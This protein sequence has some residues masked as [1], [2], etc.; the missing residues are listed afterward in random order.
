MLDPVKKRAKLYAIEGQSIPKG[1]RVGTVET[2]DGA[3]IRYARWRA[4]KDV[5]TDRPLG[6][7]ILLQGRSECIEKYYET[8][9]EFRSWGFCVLVFDWRGQGASQRLLPNAQKGHIENFNQYL[10]DLEAILTQ[11]A[12]PDCKPPL[13]IVAHSTGALVSLMAAP[14]LGNRIER[15]VLATPL[16]RL[17]NLPLRQETLQRALGIASF[18]GFSRTYL[19]K[20]PLAY[21]TRKFEGN[22]LTSDP[23]R[24]ARN[25]AIFA[26]HPFLGLGAPT[27]SWVFAACRAMA[28]VH[29]PG[30]V[31]SISVPSLI[32][33]GSDDQVVD[34]SAVERFAR[35][36]RSGAFLTI[37][38]ARHE[39]MQER[40]AFRAQA[41][42]AIGTFLGASP[43]AEDVEPPEKL[44]IKAD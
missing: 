12:L 10:E 26:K 40:D 9:D 35:K 27:V 20:N 4:A 41:M 37:S 19:A 6:T 38:G 15:M 24:F 7:I 29:E 36:L 23:A 32:I 31:N 21:M 14:A 34:T 3:S 42:S 8:I 16:L 39:I 1:A 25:Q 2:A 30:Y 11:V 33:G 22:K 5:K 44:E 28:R 18:L 43:N 17:N 13:N